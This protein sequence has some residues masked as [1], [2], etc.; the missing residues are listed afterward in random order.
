[1]KEN[2]LRILGNCLFP[3][4]LT[5]LIVWSAWMQSPLISSP[6]VAQA[7]REGGSRQGYFDDAKPADA[8]WPS[9]LPPLLAGALKEAFGQRMPVVE[10]IHLFGIGRR[11]WLAALPLKYGAE[12]VITASGAQAGRLGLSLFGFQISLLQAGLSDAGAWR[13]DDDPVTDDDL[14]AAR[15]ALWLERAALLLPLATAGL[16]WRQTGTG[17]LAAAIQGLDELVL[18]FDGER[19]ILATLAGFEIRPQDGETFG[20]Y[21]LPTRWQGRWGQLD[22]IRFD[23]EGAVFNPPFAAQAVTPATGTE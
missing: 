15:A 10:S 14:K 12:M 2:H 21:R 17:R 22:L 8:P 16:D 4:A 6:E 1:M 20:D 11:P 23:L 9:D 13:A 19:L 5:G 18:T 7:F 3:V